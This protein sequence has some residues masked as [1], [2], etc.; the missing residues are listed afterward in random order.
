LSQVFERLFL[1]LAGREKKEE[2]KRQLLEICG[3]EATLSFT[4][5]YYKESD[6]A[7]KRLSCFFGFQKVKEKTCLEKGIEN[8]NT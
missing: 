1:L 8:I 6:F 2:E 4:L 7:E 5:I 3:L